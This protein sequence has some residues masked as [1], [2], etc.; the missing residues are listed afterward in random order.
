[1]TRC[2]DAVLEARDLVAVFGG[3]ASGEALLRAVERYLANDSRAARFW[4]DVAAVV[5][6]AAPPK[7]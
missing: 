3:Q 4:M 6:E 1:M 2:D 5:A 7:H